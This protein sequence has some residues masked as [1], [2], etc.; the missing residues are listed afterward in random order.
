VVRLGSRTDLDCISLCRPSNRLRCIGYF[1]FS[2]FISEVNYVDDFLTRI[3]HIVYGQH[4]HEI[5]VNWSFGTSVKQYIITL[6]EFNIRHNNKPQGK[7]V[8]GSVAN[9][10]CMIRYYVHS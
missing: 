9:V 3:A 7:Y 10:G 4:R 2:D 1:D 6:I 5:K 8:H